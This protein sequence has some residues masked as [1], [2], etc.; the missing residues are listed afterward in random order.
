VAIGQPGHSNNSDNAATVATR[1]QQQSD[2]TATVGTVVKIKRSFCFSKEG[3]R[4]KD[5]LSG[6]IFF[7]SLNWFYS[8][9]VLEP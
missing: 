8:I 6:A 9:S 1:Q 5:C 4:I 7:M 2:N 3:Y